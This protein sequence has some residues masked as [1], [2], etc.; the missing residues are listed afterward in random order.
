MVLANFVPIYQLKSHDC[1]LIPI[2]SEILAQCQMF[3]NK[4]NDKINIEGKN[5]IY[6]ATIRNYSVLNIV[7]LYSTICIAAEAL[8]VNH[9][10]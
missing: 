4:K 9:L 6:K 10:K 3:S 1:F 5:K 7:H 8:F 2:C